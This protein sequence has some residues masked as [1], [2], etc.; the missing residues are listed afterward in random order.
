MYRRKRVPDPHFKLC[1]K[2]CKRSRNFWTGYC[3]IY[4]KR[5][6]ERERERERVLIFETV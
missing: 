3:S 6:R 4:K 1:E 5:E 2:F